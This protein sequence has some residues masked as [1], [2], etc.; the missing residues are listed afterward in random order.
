[1]KWNAGYYQSTYSFL[2][3]LFVLKDKNMKLSTRIIDFL[4][5]CSSSYVLVMEKEEGAKKKFVDTS[6]L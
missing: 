2:I 1:M 3:C 6:L 5:L 4:S